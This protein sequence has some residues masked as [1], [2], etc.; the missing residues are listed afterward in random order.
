M[1][2]SFRTHTNLHPSTVARTIPAE[3]MSL[4]L[5]AC[6]MLLGIINVRWESDTGA[7]SDH[8]EML[9]KE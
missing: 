5:L 4:L 1:A 8:S 6:I 3:A 9:L 2:G 7:C